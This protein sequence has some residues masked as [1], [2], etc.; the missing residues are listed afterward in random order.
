MSIE[1]TE[2]RAARRPPTVLVA[3]DEPAI[4]RLL[5]TVLEQRGFEVVAATSGDEALVLA[6]RHEGGVDL[7]VTDIVMPGLSGTELAARLRS[8]HPNLDVLFISGYTQHPEA[9]AVGS[10]D[11]TTGQTRFL[12]KPFAPN[13]LI[14]SLR[15]IVDPAVWPSPS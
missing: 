13:R 1:S 2:A 11:R 14:D 6:D 4:R 10:R 8:A 12:G 9:V 3:E 7:L 5:V 15:E